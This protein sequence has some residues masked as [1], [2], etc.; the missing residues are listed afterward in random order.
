MNQSGRPVGNR[1]RSQWK[2]EDVQQ[3]QM[4]HSVALRIR[5]RY[6]LARLQIRDE[7]QHL[8]IGQRHQ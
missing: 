3:K 4:L 5:Q 7:V 1:R 8:V 6:L 2:K